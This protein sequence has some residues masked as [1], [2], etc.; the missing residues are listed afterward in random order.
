MKTGT[1][2]L[3]DINGGWSF[4]FSKNATK[5]APSVK[6]GTY[7]TGLFS[8]T[9]SGYE[10]LMGS[11]YSETV[12]SGSG[13][14]SLLMNATTASDGNAYAIGQNGEIVQ[15][16]LPANVTATYTAPSG[17]TIDQ[18][19]DIWT[20]VNDSFVE[21]LLFTYQTAT[22]TYIGF[23]RVD[24]P[25]RNDT[26]ITLAN[27]NVPHAGCVSVNDTSFVTDGKF[28]KA[29]NP[30]LGI[31]AVAQINVGGAYTTV[32][33][34][35]AGSYCAI[36]GNKSYLSSQG[37]SNAR[38]WL[39]DGVNLQ[40]NFQ[41]DI[42]D[43]TVT[44]VTNEG[45]VIKVFCTGKNGTTKI[46]TFSGSNFS[47]EADFEVDSTFSDSPAHG[48]VDTWMNQLTWRTQSGFVWTYGAIKKD[49]YRT[50]AHRVSQIT[51]DQSQGFVK[52]LYGSNLYI[53]KKV[54]ST[55]TI[56]YINPL[57]SGNQTSSL[58]SDL[59]QLPHKSTISYIE[60]IFANYVITGNST[61]GNSFSL[62]LYKGEET[63]DQLAGVATVPN[64][65]ALQGTKLYYYPIRMKIS[66][67]DTFY[68]TATWTGVIKDIIV[69][70]N[71]E[72]NAL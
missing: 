55:F 22:N 29:Y 18:Y 1:I 27:R 40:P 16:T 37:G 20:H 62:N 21:C 36:V 68:M 44:A 50:G 3:N 72:D 11:A 33:V 63:V 60:V 23:K 8:N 47:E 71:F 66:D 38:L 54:G 51:T 7:Y 32:S 14:N 6:P 10:G 42:R 69:H 56:V 17:V 25:T 46:K 39:W 31:G 15:I 52:N 53:C 26:Y 5:A 61:S 35:D 45:G 58:K 28:V 43:V 13:I 9:R 70:Y 19:K 34:A 65:N 41:Y 2:R 49:L 64:D 57:T 30:G 12:V 24:S 4:G 48:M 59:Y 67:I